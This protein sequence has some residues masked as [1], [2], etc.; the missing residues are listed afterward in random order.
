VPKDFEQPDAVIFRAESNVITDAGRY[1]ILATEST[2]EVIAE[3]D[4]DGAVP[5]E[6]VEVSAGRQRTRRRPARGLVAPAARCRR[7]RSQ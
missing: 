5:T 3:I 7:Q 6:S 2:G 4:T 1:L